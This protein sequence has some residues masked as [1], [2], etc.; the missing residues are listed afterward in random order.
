MSINTL[1]KTAVAC[2]LGLAPLAVTASESGEEAVSTIAVTGSATLEVK[3]DQAV[4]SFGVDTEAASAADALALNSGRMEQVVQ[5][6][7][8]AGIQESN[9][10]TARFNIHPVYERRQDPQTGNH[11]QALKGYRVSNLLH[12]ETGDLDR[13]A[14]VIDAAVTAGAN[15][16]ERLGFGL[17]RAAR[18]R[19]REQLIQQAVE[20]A[21]A[22]ATQAAAPLGYAITGL[23]HMSV[24]DQG[25]P[26]P[27]YQDTGRVEMAMAAAPPPIFAG[28]QDIQATV[29]ATFLAS[30]K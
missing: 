27:L 8:R 29:N 7:R 5:A 10:S 14:A 28:D 9:I 20:D 17:S 12:V 26:G 21:R 15:R 4:I 3:A 6:I 30:R 13:V 1:F 24:A 16:I 22:K 18:E 25:H 23:K 11:V 2:V 19:A